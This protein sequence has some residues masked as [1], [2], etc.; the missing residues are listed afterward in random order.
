MIALLSFMAASERIRELPAAWHALMCFAVG[1]AA[2]GVLCALNYH[3]RLT[4]FRRWRADSDKFFADAIDI[5]T[6]YDNL[7]RLANNAWNLLPI[8]VGYV[9]FASFIAGAVLP[10]RISRRMPPMRHSNRGQSRRGRPVA[11]LLA[12]RRATG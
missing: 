10:S 7:N 8:I 1:I 11:A 5:K 6:L 4:L 3:L 9:A 12:T 2:C